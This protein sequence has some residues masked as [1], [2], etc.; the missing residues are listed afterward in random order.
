MNK[1]R[2]LAKKPNIRILQFWQVLPFL[3]STCS[4]L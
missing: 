2:F 3:L 1:H 4:M